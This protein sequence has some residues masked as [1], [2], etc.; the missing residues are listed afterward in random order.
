MKRR[1]RGEMTAGAGR[2]PATERR[3][4]ETLREVTKREAMRLELSF[5]RRSENAGLDAGGARGLV[6]LQHTV[7]LAQVDGHRRLVSRRVAARLNAAD[8]ARSPAE[9]GHTRLGAARPIEHCYLLLGARI[10]DHIRCVAVI[11]DK[12]AYIIRK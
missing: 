1:E 2:D 10:G 12:P 4:L 7:K 9:R 8:D 3:T 6:N 11:A 5:Q